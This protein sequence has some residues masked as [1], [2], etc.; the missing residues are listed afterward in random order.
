M[1]LPNGDLFM[2]GSHIPVPADNLVSA[3]VVFVRR[4]C[5]NLTLQSWP[6]WTDRVGLVFSDR[7]HHVA[8]VFFLRMA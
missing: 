5:S 4:V 6:L 7:L 8:L 1:P 2:F 3:F